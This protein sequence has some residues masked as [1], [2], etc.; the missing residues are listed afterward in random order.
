MYGVVFLSRIKPREHIIKYDIKSTIRLRKTRLHINMIVLFYIEHCRRSAQYAHPVV[1]S[2]GTDVG[3]G[4]GC[5]L[6]AP[7]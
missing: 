5:V 1:Q 6:Y 7:I 2:F 3:Y 4:Y